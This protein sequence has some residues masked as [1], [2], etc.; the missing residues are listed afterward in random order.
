MQEIVKH[1]P[2]IRAAHSSVR[3]VPSKL[4]NIL[5]PFTEDYFLYWGSV[6]TINNVRTILW[7]ICREPIGV[8]FGQVN[9]VEFIT[10]SF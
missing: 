4:T 6:I 8:S 2:A 7:T 1:L 9:N 5:N 10:N 3:I